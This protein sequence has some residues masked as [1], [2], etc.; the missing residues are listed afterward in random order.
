VQ[1]K[2]TEQ[3]SRIAREVMALTAKAVE[4]A[5]EGLSEEDRLNFYRVINLIA[6][7]IQQLSADGIRE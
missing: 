3:G 7:N 4:Q 5:G 2:L 1:L 6:S